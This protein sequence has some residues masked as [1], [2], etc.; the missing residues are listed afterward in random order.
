MARKTERDVSSRDAPPADSAPSSVKS[1]RSMKC[2]FCLGSGKRSKEHLLSNPICTTLGVDRA[3]LTASYNANTGEVGYPT[4]LDDKTVKL[5][6][7]ECNSGW[8]SRLEQDTAAALEVWITQSDSP[9]GAEGWNH[10]S[11]WLAK[12]AL[13]FS[14]AEADARRF[15]RNPTETAMPDITACRNLG[16]GQL[17]A[18]LECGVARANG[19]LMWEVGNPT[20]TCAGQRKLSA[21]AVNAAAFNLGPLQFWVALPV[22]SADR[23]RMPPGVARLRPDLTYAKLRLGRDPMRLSEIRAHYSKGAVDSFWLA[24]ELAQRDLAE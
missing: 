3:T 6:C 16:S 15:M 2:P 9:L 20:V 10:L 23:I 5:P 7:E 8:M 17:P 12:T 11:R 14:F 4:Q 19:E 18:T 13:V 1:D 24:V 22:I 21:R